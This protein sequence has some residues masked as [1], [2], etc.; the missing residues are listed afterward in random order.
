MLIYFEKIQVQMWK[1]VLDPFYIIWMFRSSHPVFPT[2]ASFLPSF[3][4][5]LRGAIFLARPNYYLATESAGRKMINTILQGDMLVCY[6]HS[7]R[8]GGVFD[9]LVPSRVHATVQT[10]HPVDV[11]C[12]FSV[13]GID[14][15]VLVLGSTL[16]KTPRL[17]EIRYTF[18]LRL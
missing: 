10:D 3:L 14:A 11:A 16:S 5:S 6:L 1:K 9:A 4:S 12:V 15:N 7:I 2:T 8:A 18:S 13:Q 17:W